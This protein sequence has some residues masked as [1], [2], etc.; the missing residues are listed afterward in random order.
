MCRDGSLV[1]SSDFYRAMA[2]FVGA[3]DGIDS[4]LDVGCGS[5][6]LASHLAASG[7]YRDVMGVDSSPQRVDGARLYAA[8]NGVAARFEARSMSELKLP[9]RSVDLTVTSFALEQTGAHLARCLAEIRRVTR[10]MIVLF[11]PT[12][13]FSPTLASLWHTPRSGWA[14]TYQTTLAD[15]GV[16]YATRPNL[17]YHYFNPGTVFV[18]DLEHREHPALRHPQLFRPAWQ[19][20]PGGVAFV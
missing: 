13:E 11:E 7:R 17:L 12:T 18:I 1:H 8:L 3:I 9:D 4:V 15:W 14:T 16:A 10:K 6:F 19:A 5:G 2:N 20:W